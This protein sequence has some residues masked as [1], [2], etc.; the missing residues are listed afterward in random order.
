M[1]RT[2]AEARVHPS[3]P[4]NGREPLAAAVVSAGLH[5]VFRHP[6]TMRTKVA[7]DCLSLTVE[8]G[9][10]FGLL[11][12]NGAGKTTTL[13][14][15]LGLLRPTSGQAWLLGR[16]IGDPESRRRV[17][18][19]PENPY[20]FDRLTAREFLIFSARLAG[21]DARD[22]AARAQR[23]LERLGLADRARTPLRKYSKGMVQ[24][25]GLAHA[26]VHDPE[27]VFLDEPMSGLDPLGRREFRDLILEC[28]D[29]GT[30]VVFSSHILPDVELI[31]DRVCVLASGRIARSGTLDDLLS[32]EEDGAEVVAL[33]P[34]PLLLPPRF[35]GVS[36]VAHGQRVRLE[37]P[38]TDLV[39]PL[40]AHLL[41]KEYRLVSVTPRRRSLESVVLEAAGA[42]R[43]TPNGHAPERKRRRAG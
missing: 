38:R 6:W 8:R 17:G 10:I 2:P 35:A 32:G 7:V 21:L 16:P 13:K 37:V 19:L 9:E 24:R 12:P 27:L 11:G 29:R 1:S 23:W 4:E 5:K 33:G 14:M 39:D 36:N 31:C 22:A 34:G 25:V 42:A 28:R 3:R 20:F 41:A 40:V 43:E 15:L 26:L 18:Y 30:T